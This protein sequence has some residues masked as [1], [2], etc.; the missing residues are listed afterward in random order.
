MIIF[1]LYD[2]ENKTGYVFVHKKASKFFFDKYVLKKDNFVFSN[3]ECMTSLQV[4]SIH[5]QALVKIYGW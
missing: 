3:V 1:D 2:Y 5:G 4:R